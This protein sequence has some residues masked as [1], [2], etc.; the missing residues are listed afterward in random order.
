MQY[1][2]NPPRVWSRVQN[3]CTYALD[4]TYKSVFVPLNNETVPLAVANY[5]EKI[6]YKAQPRYKFYAINYQNFNLLILPKYKKLAEQL[7]KNS[8]VT[9]NY[10]Q[11][12]N[13]FGIPKNI[14]PPK[15]SFLYSVFI[16]YCPELKKKEYL[17]ETTAYRLLERTNGFKE[18]LYDLFPSL[19]RSLKKFLNNKYLL[20]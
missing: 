2:P 18:N 3:Q 10:N 13:R 8:L 15:N 17:P 12:F 11:I 9:H 16:E 6:L 19:F 14:M 5:Q 20:K 7:T 4:N 1:N